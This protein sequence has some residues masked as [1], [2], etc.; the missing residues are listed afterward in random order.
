MAY[1]INQDKC[2]KCGVCAT[3]CPVGAIKL[4]DG[5]YTIDPNLCIMC[6]SCA[7][8]CPMQAPESKQVLSEQSYTTRI[9]RTDNGSKK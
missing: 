5:K 8:V 1:V 7:G 6:G 3:V 2:I 9:A 4:V